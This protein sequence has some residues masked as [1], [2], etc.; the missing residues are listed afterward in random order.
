M[1]QHPQ[2]DFVMKELIERL[3]ATYHGN[4]E[5]ETCHKAAD[6]LERLTAERDAAIEGAAQEARYNT[7]LRAEITKNGEHLRY[8]EGQ[9]T[10]RCAEVRVLT[11]ENA[12]LKEGLDGW[13][14]RCLDAEVERDELAQSAERVRVYKQRYFGAI[15]ERDALRAGLDAALDFAGTVAGGASW[16][17]DVWKEHEAAIAGEKK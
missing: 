11:T 13:H 17:D 15:A 5:Y 2:A 8:V 10:L 6:A 16:W 7:A 12:A 4:Y 1:T 14:S 9:E 3:R